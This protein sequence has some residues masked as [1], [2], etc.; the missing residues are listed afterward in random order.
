VLAP[1]LSNYLV[2]PF[3]TLYDGTGKVIGTDDDWGTQAN[4]AQI[5]GLNPGS[6]DAAM[7]VTLPAGAYTAIISGVNGGTGIARIDAYE[8]DSGNSAK[9]YALSTRGYA[10]RTNAMIGGFTVNGNAGT[11][12]RMLIRV[13]GPS[14]AGV[15]AMDDPYMEIYNAT[16][17]LIMINDDWS[18][19][20][21][22]LAD[23]SY[24]DFQPTVTYYNEQNIFATGLAPANRREPC[25][26]LDLAPGSYTVVIKP[27]EDLTSNPAQPAKPGVAAV[28]VFEINP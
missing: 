22:Q 9:L 18:T 13:R 24:D 11:T 27:F 16:G 26:M 3:L 23:G 2:D 19:G 15:A 12:K 17:D 4:A 10:D 7:L 1:F 21:K 14:I 25:V 8:A 6:K 5:S 28:D 20:S